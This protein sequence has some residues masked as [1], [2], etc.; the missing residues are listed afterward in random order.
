MKM[1]IELGDFIIYFFLKIMLH[2]Y[3]DGFMWI[4]MYC[5][6]RH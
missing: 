3:I 6:Q 1:D 2:R 5:E 4:S